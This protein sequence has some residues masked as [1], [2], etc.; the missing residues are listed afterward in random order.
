MGS[1]IYARAV[2]T[3]VV[4]I[5]VDFTLPFIDATSVG[6]AWN[7]SSYLLS[8]VD[9]G[10]V[11]WI[12]KIDPV[13]YFG[14]DGDY[15]YGLSNAADI[16][17]VEMLLPNVA[18]TIEVVGGLATNA[19]EFLGLETRAA[20]G[21]VERAADILLPESPRDLPGLDG[22]ALGAPVATN[23]GDFATADRM[24]ALRSRV[25][26]MISTTENAYAH[27]NGWG[28]AP[29]RGMLAVPADLQALA[30]Q[31][32]K[33]LSEDRD[34]ARATVT[35]TPAPGGARRAILYDVQVVTR[36]GNG[37]SVTT[38]GGG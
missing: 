36:W 38:D 9:S 13:D 28:S 21:V 17:T 18:Y 32:Q 25:L 34:I 4:R 2:R 5:Q 11:P 15:G 8:R 1:I 27:L 24:T 22:Q 31:G 16:W 3:N 20:A 35:C 26:H 7:P 6:D 12:A 19:F 30:L 37:L 29:R 10:S 33:K 23:A 14:L